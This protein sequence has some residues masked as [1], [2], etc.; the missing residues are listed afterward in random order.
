MV[1]IW[2]ITKVSPATTKSIYRDGLRGWLRGNKPAV[3]SITQCPSR[4]ARGV[5]ACNHSVGAGVETG[6]SQENS[7]LQAQ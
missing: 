6:G 2:K 5:C 1:V 7:K 3:D 4:A